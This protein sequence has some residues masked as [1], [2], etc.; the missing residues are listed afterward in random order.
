M[1]KID[2]NSP[3]SIKEYL[4]IFNY[5]MQKKWGQ[6]FL[7]NKEARY[8]LVEA[9]GDVKNKNIWEVGSGLG[10]M[11]SL[12][13][14][15]G[16]NLTLFEID[17]GFVQFLQANFDNS[18]KIKIIEG[19]ALKLW[20]NE[21]SSQ[22]V[23]DGFFSCLPYNISVSLL[24]SFFKERVIFDKM[25]IT[26]Q[27]EVGD[28]ILNKE[29]ISS[30]FSVFFSYFYST[31]HVKDMPPSFFWPQPHVISSSI[32]LI[33]KTNRKANCEKLFISL[34]SALFSS[35]RQNI[36]NN[37]KSFFS[38]NNKYLPLASNIENI[39]KSVLINTQKRAESLD[40]SQFVNL[41]N[42]VYARSEK[43]S[44]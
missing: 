26:V 9:F 8:T 11:T 44:L 31:T 22:G 29:N 33:K 3:T 42:E 40:V 7:I 19:D 35:K 6:N 37:L 12:L 1:I 28:K 18:K 15:K 13:Y 4:N 14:D 16:A 21:Y 41:C 39:L 10:A 23:P 17:R 5:S 36:K 30:P 25:L 32:L 20:K 27:K 43:V 2:Y 38:A 34:V 24:L